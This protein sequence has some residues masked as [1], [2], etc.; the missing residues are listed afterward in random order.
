MASAPAAAGFARGPAADG[1]RFDERF[2]RKLESLVLTIRRSAR[3]SAGLLRANRASKRVGAGLEFAD[4]RDYAAGDDLRY[5]DWNLYGRLG[6]L[7]LRLFQEEEDLLVEVLVDA[8]ASMGVGD[9]PKLD[10]ALQI[11]AALA[12]VGLANLDRVALSPLR[13]RGA[14]ALPRA[15]QGGDPADPAVARRRPGGR[16][17]WAGGGR[18]RVSRPAAPAAARAGDPDLRLLRSGGSSRGAGSAAPSPAGGGRH[19]GERAAGDG[20]RAARRRRAARHRDRRIARADHL[21]VGAGR[22][23]AAPSDAAARSRGLLP[24]AR[25]PLLH[26]RLGPG[27]RRGGAAHVPRRRPA[28]VAAMGLGRLLSGP[29]SANAVLIATAIG[30]AVIGVLYLV[31][32]RRRRVVVSF[33]PRW[34]DAAGPRRTTSWARYLRDVLSFLLAAALLALIVVATMDA[35]ASSSDADGRSVVV[36]I[37]RSASMSARDG[38]TGN[39]GNVRN[40]RNVRS[41]SRL[42]AAKARATALVD[43]LGPADRALVASFAADTVAEIGFE[44]DAGR[45]RRAVAAVAPSEEPGD[46]PRALTFASAVLRGRPRPTVVLVSDG[47]F[48]EEAR[49]ALPAGVD[50]RYAGVGH[51]GARAGGNVGIISFAARRVPADPS[52]VEAAVVVQNFSARPAALALE[53]SAGATTVERV[54]LDLGPGERRRHQL[55]N[56]FAA[57]ARLQA[58]LLTAD[59]KPLADGGED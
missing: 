11:G 53:I 21:A 17:R 52:A 30:T 44:A 50:V 8:S 23:P 45:L 3:M 54:R 37:D 56:V 55:P 32:L 29:L 7:A 46:L 48:T 10:L 28:A 25:H 12:Y 31:R 35:R 18:A 5:L 58:R 47:A 15:R 1:D 24:R 2:L 33:A 34:L 38:G 20:A 4:H 16:A 42:D 40:V 22:V 27:V 36:L 39:V 43:G 9:P 6:R 59:G 41:T 14:G 13:G 51:T 19:P 26:G 49:R 57:D